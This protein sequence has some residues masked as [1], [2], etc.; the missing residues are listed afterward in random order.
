MTGDIASNTHF[1]TPKSGEENRCICLP[2]RQAPGNPR[3][4]ART[5]FKQIER[6]DRNAQV[7]SGFRR[8]WRHWIGFVGEAGDDEFGK[9]QLRPIGMRQDRGAGVDDRPSTVAAT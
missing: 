2:S 9:N 7:K 8:R 4:G 1:G 3:K 6:P 5:K